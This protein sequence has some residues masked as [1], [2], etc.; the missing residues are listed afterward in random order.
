[1]AVLSKKQ[2]EEI[3]EVLVSDIYVG[4]CQATGRTSHA[5]CVSEGQSRGSCNPEVMINTG[6]NPCVCVKK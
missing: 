1:M 5:S 2:A 6:P 4:C 3:T